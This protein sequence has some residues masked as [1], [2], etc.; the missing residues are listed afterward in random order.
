MLVADLAQSRTHAW[1][2]DLAD[3]KQRTFSEDFTLHLPYDVVD[4]NFNPNGRKMEDYTDK[5]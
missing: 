4:Q 1:P 5:R 2:R 3:A